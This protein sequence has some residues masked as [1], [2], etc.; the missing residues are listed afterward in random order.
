[1]W[2]C[3][4]LLHNLR[5]L[6]DVVAMTRLC[7]WSGTLGIDVNTA[8]GFLISVLSLYHV[9]LSVIQ[10]ET[11]PDLLYKW[12]GLHFCKSNMLLLLAHTDC[13]SSWCL[14]VSSH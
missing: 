14:C 12:N 1:M 6:T 3:L 8:S 4:W 13:I 2:V 5:S 11:V 7:G 10:H 9:G